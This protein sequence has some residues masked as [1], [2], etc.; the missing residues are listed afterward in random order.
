[1]SFAF[2]FCDPA[3]QQICIDRAGHRR[4]GDRHPR[5]TARVDR[6]RLEL[7]AM[8]TSALTSRSLF[9]SVH[10]STYF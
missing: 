9:D 1:M 7:R 8:T 5:L 3:P 4:S 6:L 2:G 10:V